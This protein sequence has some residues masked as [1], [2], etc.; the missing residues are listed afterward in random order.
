LNNRIL[1][2]IVRLSVVVIVGAWIANLPEPAS[3]SALHFKNAIVVLVG[4]V[5][6]GKILYDTFFGPKRAF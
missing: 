5:M 4:I 6:C 3:D 2:G 1:Q